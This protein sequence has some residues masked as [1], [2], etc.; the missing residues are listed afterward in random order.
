MARQKKNEPFA[1][2][3]L[4]VLLVGCVATAVHFCFAWSDRGALPSKELF[5]LEAMGVITGGYIVLYALAIVFIDI[6]PPKREQHRRLR[7]S[8]PHRKPR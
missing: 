8:L 7:E 4:T 5:V 6:F 2:K 3:V 1:M